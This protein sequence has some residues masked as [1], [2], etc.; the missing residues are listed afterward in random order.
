MSVNIDHLGIK[1]I[2]VFK[3]QYD[4]FPHLLSL[5]NLGLKIWKV[6][7]VEPALKGEAYQKVCE[8]M[9]LDVSFGLN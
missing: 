6:L 2:N 5:N 3:L 8:V 9:I 1:S 4:S 7:N